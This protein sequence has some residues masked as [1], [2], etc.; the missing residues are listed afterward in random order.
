[1]LD[2]KNIVNNRELAIERW[3]ARGLDG[4]AIVT[5]LVQLDEQRKKAIL[6]HDAAKHRQ[7]ELSEVFKTKGVSPAALAEARVT[8]KSLSDAIKEHADAIKAAEDGIRGRL[9]E[10]PNWPQNSVPVGKDSSENVE[11]RRWGTPRA[12]D[13]EAKGHDEVGVRLGILDFEQASRISGSG[14]AV[15]RGAGARLERA[16]MM[17]MLDV[18]TEI[19]GFTEIY[20]P[21][22]VTRETMEGT[23]QLPKFEDDAFKTT[24]DLFLI[25]T[26]EVS[27][28]NLHRGELLAAEDL[29]KR[30]TAY[31]SCF[32]REAGSYG[33]DVKGLTRLHQFQKVEMVKLTTPETS[34]AELESMV[35][36]AGSILERLG[37]PYRVLLLCTGD[38][39]FSSAKTYDLEVWLPSTQAFREV[40]SCSNCESFQARR[41][42]IRYRPAAGEKPE[43]VHTLN[44]SGLSVGR[45]LMAILDNYQQ[46][47]G[48]VVIPPALRPYMGGLD[49]LRPA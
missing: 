38:M 31:S 18:H 12:L 34:D 46:A 5:E 10:L 25:P 28:T 16:L 1:M 43:F 7:S 49:V 42:S 6:A 39:G 35:A 19:H 24:D 3:S 36:C 22:L 40:S 20:G 44:G 29:P 45:T 37:L 33:K 47:D 17:F 8:L 48:S 30:Y 26:S 2:P 27:V 21:Y 13:F 11:V 15:Y 23:G 9:L 32:R 41:A 14:F 4:V